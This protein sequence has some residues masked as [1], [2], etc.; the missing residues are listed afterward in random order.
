MRV[1]QNEPMTIGEVDLSK[2]VSDIKS[3]DDIP[4]IL[5]GLQF[6]YMTIPLRNAIFQLLDRSQG[7]PVQR[8]SR[9]GAVADSGLRRNSP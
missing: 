3:R 4:R 5:R 7:Q 8:S 2:M 6:I 1:V 9:Q